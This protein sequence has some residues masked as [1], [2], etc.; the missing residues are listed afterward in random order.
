MDWNCVTNSK[1]GWCVETSQSL[2]C[3]GLQTYPETWGNWNLEL[4]IPSCQWQH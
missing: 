3:V 2:S 4:A 1:V